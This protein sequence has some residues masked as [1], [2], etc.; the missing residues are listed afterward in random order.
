MTFLLFW[1]SRFSLFVPGVFGF[2][3]GVALKRLEKVTQLLVIKWRG[4]GRIADS[5]ATILFRAARAICGGHGTYLFC[6]WGSLHQNSS[7][8]ITGSSRVGSLG[9][10]RNGRRRL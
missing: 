8:E 3:I 2:D 9:D 5:A 10:N 4:R 1:R 7:S 6:R